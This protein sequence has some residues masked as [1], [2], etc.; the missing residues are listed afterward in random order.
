MA[1]NAC[2]QRDFGTLKYLCDKYC[3]H[4]KPI[5]AKMKAYMKDNDVNNFEYMW[6]TNKLHYI[7]VKLLEAKSYVTFN[8]IYEFITNRY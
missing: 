1:K 2:D 3:S 5:L 6:N 7:S 4:D 8:G